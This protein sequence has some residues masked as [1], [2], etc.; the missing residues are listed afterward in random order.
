MKNMKKRLSG[1]VAMIAASVS[2]IGFSACQDDEGP[3]TPEQQNVVEIAAEDPN[4]NTLSSAI[5]EADLATTLSSD[6]PF[7]I[8]AP[9]DAAFGSFLIDNDLT[10]EELLAS[11]SLRDILTYHV[12][13]STRLSSDLEPGA[14]SS[15]E[16][17]NFF[18]SEDPSGNFWIN[19][20]AQVTETD[21]RAS[22]GVIHGLDAVIV[23][24][25]QSI[26]EIAVDASEASNPQFTQL[27]AALERV[28]LLEELNGSSSDN[29]TVFA[30]TDEAFDQLY[31]DL[32]VSGMDEISDEN[33]SSILQYHV[34]PARAFSQDLRQDATLP[35][36][37]E[38]ANLTVDLAN[39][40]INE[41]GL[42]PNSLNNHAVNGVIHS[43]DRVLIPTDL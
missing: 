33:L 34:V 7:T 5:E 25:S 31:E 9:T 24:P 39:L 16:G 26:V 11:P 23:I 6:G 37:L 30:P 43:I 14:V 38:G 42:I 28:E 21:I 32:G 22:N 1:Y 10:A 2:L 19:G 4:F 15:L 3:M 13:S 18:I 20:S 35:T 27:V 8:F 29:Y 12:I 41:S 36:L 40:Q 17:S